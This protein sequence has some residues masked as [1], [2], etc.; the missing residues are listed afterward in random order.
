MPLLRP[1]PSAF[2]AGTA[3]GI[4]IVNPISASLRLAGDG[5]CGARRDH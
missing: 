3:A 1:I 4:G 2:Q 5:R